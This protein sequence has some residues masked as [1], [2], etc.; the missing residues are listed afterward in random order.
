MAKLY[1]DALSEKYGIP[2][3][4]PVKDLPKKYIQILLYGNNGEKMDIFK[5]ARRN[6]MEE[7]F[8]GS[9]ALSFE[10]L[11]N[12]L[13]RRLAETKSEFMR[14]EIGKFLRN[15]TCKACHGKRL[16]ESALSIKIDGKD[17]ID[18]CDMP[19]SELLPYM[20]NLKL[21]KYKM[22]V[23]EGILKEINARL[24]FLSDVGLGYL[25]LSRSAETLSGGEAQRIR[26]ATQIGSGLVGVLYILDEPSI[27][28]HQRDN[29]K[30]L[31]TLKN[32]RD[33][34]NTLIVVEHDEDTM[35]EADWIVD[36]GPYAG[37]HGGEIVANGP[38]E[39]VLKS[40]NS[41]TAKFLRGEEKIEI[42]ESRK[43]PSGYLKVKGA[44]KNNLKNLD[45]DIPLGVLTVVT[46][47]SG[48]GKSSLVNE[49]VYPYL[50]NALNGSKLELGK[51]DKIEGIEQLDKVICIDQAPIGR[52]PRSNP[53]TY[54]GVFTPIRELLQPHLMQR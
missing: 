30:L 37:V 40:P 15:Q 48:S 49:V 28:L 33:L 10:G 21:P 44:A 6:K 7:R 3:D 9:H 34:G 54:T 39:E 50:S 42:P 2:L 18:I 24:K 35:R 51:F 47:V 27:G 1:F 14:F 5:D 52:T 31:A 53:A 45:V 38:L 23:A 4:K 29:E 22:V 20:Q 46:G 32:L 25:T 11:I 19:V 12:N 8:R 43:Q 16:N 17:I 36:V 41:V 13:K 26:L